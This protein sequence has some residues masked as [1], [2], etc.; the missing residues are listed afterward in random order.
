MKKVQVDGVD[1]DEDSI[2]PVMIDDL[3]KFKT[4]KFMIIWK[5]WNIKNESWGEING[6]IYNLVLQHVRKVLESLLK[7][8]NNTI[9][10]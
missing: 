2:V 1:T 5:P 9:R 6:M 4:E 3:F 10:F 7:S 8:Q